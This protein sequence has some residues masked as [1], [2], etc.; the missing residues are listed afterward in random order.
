MILQYVALMTCIIV[1]CYTPSWAESMPRD[2]SAIFRKKL[3]SGETLEV[4]TMRTPTTRPIIAPASTP[5]EGSFAVERVDAEY[6]E[7]RLI[8]E[9]ETVGRIVWSERQ[10]TLSGYGEDLKF[11]VLDA[12]VIEGR[13]V[14]V[15][16]QAYLARFVV[17]DLDDK[18]VESAKL[19]GGAS[20]VRE[21]DARGIRTEAAMIMTNQSFGE[22]EI[23]MS[24]RR[25]DKLVVERYRVADLLAEPKTGSPTDGRQ[26]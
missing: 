26:R 23:E 12:A 6:R 4:V 20:L 8:P 24:V 14:V 9:G 15:C 2:G 11:Q 7:Y 25:L 18:A 22:T 5:E 17:V 16:R 13:L 3:V 10:P 21:S 1:A 19:V